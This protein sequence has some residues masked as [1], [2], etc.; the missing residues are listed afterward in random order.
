P[1]H[2]LRGGLRAV[3]GGGLRAR[4]RGRGGG[5][6]LGV[7]LHRAD[8]LTGRARRAPETVPDERV[9]R[10]GDGVGRGG[11]GALGAVLAGGASRRFGSPKGLAP[12]LGG[13]LGCRPLA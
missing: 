11:R 10:S 7:L 4:L 12:F 8:V 9:P 5:L 1:A 6:G 13:P 3:L 2:A